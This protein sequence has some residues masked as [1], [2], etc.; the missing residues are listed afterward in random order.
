M[1]KSEKASF[2]GNHAPAEM[3]VPES[4]FASVG[5]ALGGLASAEYFGAEYCRFRQIMGST[6]LDRE[7]KEA[8]FKALFLLYLN[9]PEAAHAKVESAFL[10]LSNEFQTRMFLEMTRRAP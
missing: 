5:E 8:A 2:F 3:C 10:A 9:L 7:Q 4:R 6:K 1:S